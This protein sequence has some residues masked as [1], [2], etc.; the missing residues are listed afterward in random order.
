MSHVH[1][2][3]SRGPLCMAIPRH[4][5]SYRSDSMSRPVGSSLCQSVSLPLRSLL[6][7]SMASHA[8]Q[9]QPRLAFSMHFDSLPSLLRRLPGGRFQA[10]ICLR[11]AFLRISGLCNAISARVVTCSRA[12]IPCQSCA[13]PFSTMP[14]RCYWSRL[15]SSPCHIV[16]VRLLTSPCRCASSFCVAFPFRCRSCPG[17][18]SCA[19]RCPLDSVK[20]ASMLLPGFTLPFTAGLFLICSDPCASAGLVAV[21]HLFLS[22]RFIATPSAIAFP[23][24]NAMSDLIKAGHVFA[25][26]LLCCAVRLSTTPSRIHPCPAL[27]PPRRTMRVSAAQRRGPSMLHCSMPFHC[28]QCNAKPSRCCLM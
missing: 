1:A 6:R 4:V 10:V 8:L 14:P 16:E 17:A 18:S 15:P 20:F 7:S 28:Y 13:P 5:I 19:Q 22:A 24:L 21:S 25:L 2:P 27:A 11:Y 9:S 26:S 12:A 23:H 3:P